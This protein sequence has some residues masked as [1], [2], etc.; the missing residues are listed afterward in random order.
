MAW[1]LTI[2][3][4]FFIGVFAGMAYWETLRPCRTLVQPKSIRWFNNLALV[5][6]NTFVLRLLFPLA[7]VALALMA[8]ERGWGVLNNIAIS[9][10]L[11]VIVSVVVL[12][13]V[14][15]LQHVLFHAI[16][17]LWRLHRVHHAD[18]DYDVTTGLRFHPIEIMI[19]MLIKFSAI[20][21]LGPPV[22]AI[23]AFEII[24]NGCAMFN[25]SN[26]VIPRHIDR[27]LRLFLVTPDVHRV[28]HSSIKRE[29]NSNY[30]F[31]LPWWDR[32]FGTYCAQPRLGHKQMEIGLNQFREAKY[33]KL[34]W[35]LL[36][37]FIGSAGDYSMTPEK[38]NS[39]VEET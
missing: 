11:A 13:F 17:L 24:L 39:R 15:Y 34:H 29:T 30:G 20:L 28:H 32:L 26:I 9:P 31:S 22:I 38:E 23:I 1:E 27:V 36:I 35:L 25:H 3:L 5:V 6:V 21:V 10:F 14:I 7:A 2:R 16:P 33:V 4:V 18:T 19:S 12:D 8:E 37:P